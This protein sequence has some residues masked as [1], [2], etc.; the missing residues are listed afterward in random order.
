M[1]ADRQND[2]RTIKHECKRFEKGK[3]VVGLSSVGLL[4]PLEPSLWKSTARD[5]FTRIHN[6]IPRSL[7][8]ALAGRFAT[9]GLD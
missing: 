3:T 1:C 9:L 4:T 6:S 7:F 5:F 8:N 2:Q